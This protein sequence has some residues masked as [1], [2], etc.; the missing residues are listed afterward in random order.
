MQEIV[1]MESTIKI[2]TGI[3]IENLAESG[4]GAVIRALNE[5]CKDVVTQRIVLN[6]DDRAWV[7]SGGAVITLD[8]RM[9]VSSEL[10]RSE[11]G[12]TT[13]AKVKEKMGIK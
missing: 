13:L 5:F 3:S 8:S 9:H 2:R 1:S 7:S 11:A 10:T 12:E 4:A 6:A